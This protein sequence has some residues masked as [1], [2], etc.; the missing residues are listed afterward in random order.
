M[1]L[2]ELF[3]PSRDDVQGFDAKTGIQRV[4]KQPCQLLAHGQ[5][6][7]YHKMKTTTA[8]RN[9]DALKAEA[10]MIVANRLTGDVASVADKVF[11]RD[12]FSTS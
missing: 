10:D 11:T 12:L 8:R 7:D 5:T 2:I 4:R 6:R 9:A 3:V 1:N